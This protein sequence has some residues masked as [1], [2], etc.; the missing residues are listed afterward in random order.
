MAS[1]YGYKGPN[2]C[3]AFWQDF[4]KCYNQ[5]DKVTDCNLY[6]EDYFECLHPT[7]EVQRVK[8]IIEEADR[9]KK[10]NAQSSEKS[11]GLN[12]LSKD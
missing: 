8:T 5:A 3:F 2:R 10:A 12:I 4:L 7:K 1:G 6:R 11:N 9:Q